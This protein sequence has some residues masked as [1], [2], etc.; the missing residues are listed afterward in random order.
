[1]NGTFAYGLPAGRF[2]M[3]CLLRTRVK[4]G[5]SGRHQ[6]F[7]FRPYTHDLFDE[8]GQ[9]GLN[10]PE[11]DQAQWAGAYFSE[12]PDE[13]CQKSGGYQQDFLFHTVF[14]GKVCCRLFY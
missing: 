4:T 6:V 3:F 11:N 13:F 5:L 12:F 9:N 7:M 1:M 14:G 2:F 10:D 8:N